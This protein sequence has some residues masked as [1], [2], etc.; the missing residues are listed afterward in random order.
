MTTQVDW[1]SSNTDLATIVRMLTLH[2]KSGGTEYTGLTNA[3]FPQ[4]ELSGCLQ[5][6]RVILLGRIELP[7]LDLRIDGESIPESRRETFIRVLLPVKGAA[8][9]DLPEF[10]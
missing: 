1:D 2:E 5:L 3:I 10:E 7:C 4:H 9:G 6:D 8:I